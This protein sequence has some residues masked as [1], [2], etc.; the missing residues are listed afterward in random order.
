M[1]S[2]H[3]VAHA[4]KDGLKLIRWE[5]AQLAL[6]ALIVGSSMLKK[7]ISGAEAGRKDLDCFCA[8]CSPTSRLLGDSFFVEHNRSTR[9]L[10]MAF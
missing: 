6:S 2:W 10:A 7:P 8:P 1:N 4:W 9:S 3:M 5:S